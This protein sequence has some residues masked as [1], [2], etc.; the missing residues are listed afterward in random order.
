MQ[1]ESAATAGYHSLNA[2]ASHNEDQMDEAKIGALSNHATAT[3][4]DRVVVAALT[5]ANS[6][7][8][9]LKRVAGTQGFTKERTT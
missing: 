9:K 3:A 4:T 6:R 5:Q 2:A 8:A 1:R 7:L